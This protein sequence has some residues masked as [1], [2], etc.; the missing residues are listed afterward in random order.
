MANFCTKCGAA[1]SGPFCG[2][3]GAPI[4][5]SPAQGQNVTP[6][7]APVSQAAAAPAPVRKG[8]GVK[9]VLIVLGVFMLFGA[10][11]VAG[12]VYVGYRAKQ[13]IAQMEKDYGADSNASSGTSSSSDTSSA[14]VRTFP[15]S[16]GSGC[17]LLEGQEAARILGVAVER[18]ETEASDSEGDLCKYWVSAP[19]RR[20]LIREEMA[21]SVAGMGKA[22]TKSGQQDMENLIGGAA[23][24]LIEANGDNKD[25]DYAFSLQVWRKNGKEQWEKTE[26]L[27]TK[28]KGAAGAD[29][30]GVAMQ[31]V[32]GVG[33][34][35]TVL[36]AGH[37]IMVL[38]GDAF[39][40]LGFQQFV[41][42]RDKT[43]ALA[44]VV[45]GRM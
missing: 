7:A 20:R 11:G 38:K 16:K 6:P 36:A 12:I 4:Q 13:K 31:P 5:E 10:M 39:F 15:P 34:R 29:F 33:D 45:A 42:G 41:P 2:A 21:S 44:R 35:A 25:T 8:S 1:V 32:E 26:S 22:D 30:A 9:I 24:A 18:A 19:E 17:R 40:L 3:C 37:S 14:S 28:T 43:V 23:G 27:Q